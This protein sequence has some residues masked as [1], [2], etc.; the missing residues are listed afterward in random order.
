[1]SVIL[2]HDPRMLRTNGLEAMSVLLQGVAEG[3]V[4]KGLL[5]L[6]LIDAEN[7]ISD[8]SCEAEEHCLRW[9]IAFTNFFSQGTQCSSLG[10][11]ILQIANPQPPVISLE[12]EPTWLYAW[13]D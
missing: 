3:F 13:M 1:M 6:E 7:A 10:H 9:R 2:H 8:W 12:R 11:E 4:L 5:P